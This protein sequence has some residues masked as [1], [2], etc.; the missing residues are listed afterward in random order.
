MAVP[1]QL[2]PLIPKFVER[3]SAELARLKAAIHAGD[4]QAAQEIGHRLR[5]AAGSYGFERL[6][7][8]ASRLETAAKAGE[9]DVLVRLA[10]QMVDHLA[11]ARITY[12]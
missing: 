2:R 10:E 12:T 11:Q 5:G 8:L 3:T 4:L 9:R 1:A 7:E 6:G